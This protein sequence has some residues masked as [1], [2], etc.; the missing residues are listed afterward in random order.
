MGNGFAFMKVICEDNVIMWAIYKIKI[1]STCIWIIFI[2]VSVYVVLVSSYY[3]V[4]WLS[5]WLL[6]DDN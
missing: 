3:L 6:L 1:A 5:M 4:W 2:H